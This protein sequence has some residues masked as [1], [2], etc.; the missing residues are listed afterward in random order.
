VKYKIVWI[1][2][3]ESDLTQMWL[4]SRMRHEI[5]A[6][7]GKIDAVLSQNPHDCGESRDEG[8]R[9]LFESPVGVLFKVNE[10]LRRVFVIAAWDS[11][12]GGRK[13]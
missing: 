12:G 11:T 1:P 4:S 13:S 8:K 3:A 5:T 6:A 9:I 2:V 10:Q 7:V